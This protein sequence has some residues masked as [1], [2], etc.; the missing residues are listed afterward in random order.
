MS[1]GARL[2]VYALFAAAFFPHGG[3]NLVLLL[4]VTGIAIAVLTGI[5]LRNTLLKG[6]IT[7]F[8]MELPPYHL[9]TPR[10]VLLRTYERLKSFLFRAGKVLVPIIVLLS[11]FNSIGTDGTFGNENTPNSVLASMSKKIAPAF[12]T[13]GITEENWPATVGLFSGI[14]AKEAVVGTLDSLYNNM[15]KKISTGEMDSEGE[16][17]FNFLAS[18]K[19]A[20]LTIPENL[21]EVT[22][23]LLDPIGISIDYASNIDEASK[24]ME[25]NKNTFGSMVTLFGSKIAAFAYLLF[26]LLYF[27][28]SAAIAAIYRETNLKWTL[29]GGFWTTFMAWTTSTIFYQ[30]ATFNQHPHS[31]MFW[32]IICVSLF[33]GIVG[34]LYLIGSKRSACQEATAMLE[35]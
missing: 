2:P 32:I 29:F 9:P 11:F 25:V 13:I 6:E 7:P 8:V 12:S 23:S 18:L 17:G 22:N 15:D 3:Q 33:L 35:S 1:C 16:N 14:F 26:V 10:S 19:E 31:S 20:F 24:E 4:Y 27:P 21:K 34:L 28:C 5:I 30:S